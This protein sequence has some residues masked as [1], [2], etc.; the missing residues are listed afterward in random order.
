[1]N[2]Q[3]ILE[4]VNK[5]TNSKP[6]RILMNGF[7]GMTAITICGS[8]FTLIKSL[9]FG[10]WTNFLASSG[11]G[12]ILSIPIAITTDVISLYVVLSMAYNTAKET[13][14]DGFST[15]LVALGSFLL[16]T[17]F[18]STIYNEDYTAV[19]AVATNV[20]PTGVL[21]AQ[22]MFLAIFVGVGAAL[23]YN[24]FVD[25][26]W[27][28]KMPDS[29]PS[30]VSK[31]FESL[32][33]GGFTFVVFLA[34]RW[35]MSLTPFGTAQNFIYGL[36]QAPLASVG[37]G[38]GGVLVYM[39]VADILWMFGIHGAMVAY[40]GMM[41]IVTLMANENLAAFAAGTACPHPEWG[42]YM[43]AFLGGSGATLGLNLLMCSKLCKSS[44]Y[45]TL[46]KIALPT[47]LFNINEPIIFGTPI[48][49][50]VYYAIPFILAPLLNMAIALVCFKVGFAV[51]T[52]ASIN[53]FM[54]F[55]AYGALLTGN[56]EGAV[57][58]ILMLV[59]DIVLYFPF[60]KAADTKLYKE[61]LAN[62]A[63]KEKEKEENKDAEPAQQQA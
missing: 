5:F 35:G 19:T 40:V 22:G 34:I 50:N 7:M 30:N 52:G 56:W 13:N 54:P 51:P 36:L 4:G 6:M 26:G 29:V 42:V 15:A 8:I 57:L 38:I 49:M 20:I 53:N 58:Q 27:T 12:D 2:T 63:A 10:P 48:M 31:M 21:G 11:L 59:A 1:M 44:Q 47:S 55:V 46:G 25:R 45:K 24:F 61:E 9:P 62:E 39:I 23:I 28:I 33:P 3:K 32:I 41:P 60:F 37:G 17:P 18:T 16:L 14:H 43:L